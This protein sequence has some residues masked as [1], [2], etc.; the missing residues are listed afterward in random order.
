MVVPSLATQAW[1]NNYAI[2]DDW[3]SWIVEGQVT[4]EQDTQLLNK[5]LKNALPCLK[6][7]SIMNLYKY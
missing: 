5:S 2:V 3:T 4:G 1:I 6:G 7:G